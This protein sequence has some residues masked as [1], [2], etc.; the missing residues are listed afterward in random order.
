[1]TITRNLAFVDCRTEGSSRAPFYDDTSTEEFLAMTFVHGPEGVT[2]PE[3]K[4]AK[5]R[6]FLGYVDE[7]TPAG[8]GVDQVA[9]SDEEIERDVL[10]TYTPLTSPDGV[11][12]WTTLGPY[13]VMFRRQL[14]EREVW[15][16]TPVNHF[17]VTANAM[18]TDKGAKNQS[19]YYGDLGGLRWWFKG[20]SR[21]PKVRFGNTTKEHC[22]TFTCYPIVLHTEVSGERERYAEI[23]ASQISVAGGKRD[24]HS[25]A[26]GPL[27]AAS[28]KITNIVDVGTYEDCDLLCDL[29]Q[30]LQMNV[31][32]GILSDLT[33]EGVKLKGKLQLLDLR[34]ISG[35]KILV[36]RQPRLSR[37][38]HFD[39]IDWPCKPEVICQA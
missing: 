22:A 20:R 36:L 25:A 18:K 2:F 23:G 27:P 9:I 5:L 17:S 29:K 7:S 6:F 30:H 31:R 21:V 24:Q 1:M 15:V 13:S 26:G 35:N 16:E 14:G 8:E 32:V 12:D 10:K 33:G 4:P 11:E 37:P 19:Y 34:K 28:E 38:S 39:E 3:D